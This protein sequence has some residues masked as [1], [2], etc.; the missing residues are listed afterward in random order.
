MAQTD[1]I[2]SLVYLSAA[3]VPFSKQDL[4]TL[5]E[6]SRENNTGLGITGMLLFKDGNFL[7]VLEGDEEKVRNLYQK[8][9]R[10]PR[11][12]ECAVL[13]HGSSTQRDFPDWSMGFHDLG[14]R[15]VLS[16]PGFSTFLKTSLTARDFAHDPRRAKTLLLLF[17]DE[18][19]LGSA[20]CVVRAGK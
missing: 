19:L 12:R 11:H 2:F 8:I 5:L 17:K 6:K 4:V 3:T 10:D 7:Q 20:H 16:I 9:G 18:Q 15:D 1:Q 14:S 13:F